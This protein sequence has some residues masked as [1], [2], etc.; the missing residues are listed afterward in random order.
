MRIKDIPLHNQPRYRFEKL[1]PSALSDAELLAI[2]LQKG[3]HNEN[4]IDMCNRLM[5]RHSIEKLSGLCLAE[6]QQIK[7]IG[8]AKAMQIKAIFEFGKRTKINSKRYIHRAK[9]VFDN[10]HVKLKDE[11]REIFMVVMLDTRNNIIGE[12]VVSLGILD[13][14]LVHPREIFRPAI[15]NSAA[16]IILVHNHPSGDP[17]PSKEDLKITESIIDAGRLL[18]ISVLDHVIIGDRYWSWREEIA[19]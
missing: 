3:T 14:A 10:Y 7:G 2:V 15:K 19:I 11:K 16:K 13:G 17:S 5:Q 9:D 6:L 4:V 8:P 1:G 18:N 12:E